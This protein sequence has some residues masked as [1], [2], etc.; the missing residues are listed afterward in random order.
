MVVSVPSSPAPAMMIGRNSRDS[1]R[2]GIHVLTGATPKTAPIVGAY[3]RWWQTGAV[4]SAETHP[5]I[6][7]G[8]LSQARALQAGIGI[9]G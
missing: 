1:P 2:R 6:T 5:E 8:I 7:G 3:T 4:M 9:F